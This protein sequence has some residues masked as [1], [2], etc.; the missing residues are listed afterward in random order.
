MFG[1]S[2]VHIYP[3]HLIFAAYRTRVLGLANWPTRWWTREITLKEYVIRK[4]YNTRH[5]LLDNDYRYICRMTAT[6][7]KISYL[8]WSGLDPF[9]LI[10][11]LSKTS[12]IWKIKRT[13]LFNQLNSSR[14]YGKHFVS[15][16]H[17]IW[18][19]MVIFFILY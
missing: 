3:T 16:I 18:P 5:T 17:N 2:P 10:S 19:K 13:C 7:K 14:W 9:T 1:F 11:T 8:G 6:I 15:S 12:S 4:L